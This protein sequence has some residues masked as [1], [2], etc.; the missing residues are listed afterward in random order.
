MTD[1]ASSDFDVRAQLLDAWRGELFGAA[2]MRTLRHTLADA[3]DH[4]EELHRMERVEMLMAQALRETLRITPGP[5]D[6]AAANDRARRV[7]GGFP[8]WTD[9]VAASIVALPAPLA[10][11][12]ALEPVA[13][14]SLKAVVRLLIEHEE[15][16]VVYL[17]SCAAGRP[18]NQNEALHTVE[19]RLRVYLISPPETD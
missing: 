14:P 17:D 18:A 5:A 12:R 16:L 2:L 7:A 3:D 13:P 19:A 1:A 4:E 9:F 11:F 10:R 6:V 8:D 15:Q